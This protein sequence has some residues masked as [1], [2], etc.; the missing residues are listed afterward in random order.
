MEK[1]NQIL[2]TIS[3]GLGSFIKAASNRKALSEAKYSFDYA[4]SVVGDIRWEYERSLYAYQKAQDEYRRYRF[5]DLRF[6]RWAQS[7]EYKRFAAAED[8][9]RK[10]LDL[11]EQEQ[12]RMHK[13][14][15]AYDNMNTEEFRREAML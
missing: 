13:A 3:L 14:E 8:A 5:H 9:Y 4:Q 1:S 15:N 7:N 10:Q 12:N 11:L 6:W 2:R